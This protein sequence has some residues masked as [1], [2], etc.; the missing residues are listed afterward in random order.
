MKKKTNFV[1]TPPCNEKSEKYA[2]T[3]YIINTPGSR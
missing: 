1:L 3:I 2:T